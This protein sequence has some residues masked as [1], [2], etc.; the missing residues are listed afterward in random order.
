MLA[1]SLK[2]PPKLNAKGPFTLRYL[3]PSE[4]RLWDALVDI[5]PQSSVFCRSW[6]LS[7]VGDVH[8]LACFSGDELIAGIPLYF[9]KLFGIRVCTMPKLTQTWGVVMRP[10]PGKAVVAAERETKILRAF[11]VQLSGYRLFFQAFH[12]SLSNWLPFYWSGFRQTT[13]F[14]YVLNDLT[15]LGRVWHGLSDNVR[16]TIKKAEK[17]GLIVVP[18]SIE[19]V[20]RC[21]CLS[22]LRRGR[23][24][25]HGESLLKSIY[26]AAR[27]NDSGACFAVVDRAGTVHSACLLVWDS[28]RAYRL[29]AGSEPQLRNSGANTLGTWDAIQ[30]AAHRTRKFDFA[31]SII[32]SIEHFN[33]GFGAHQVPYNIVIKASTVIHSCLQLAGKL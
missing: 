7:A 33:R 13:R 2:G 31:G 28:N 19:E 15:D 25:P 11:A 18:C 16:C 14:T 30:F 27:N 20:Y 21:E 3:D 1:K 17:A 6:W 12:P 9:E 5:S 23:V 24:P 8:V 4:Y 10:L 26:D 32:E 22:Y 29:V